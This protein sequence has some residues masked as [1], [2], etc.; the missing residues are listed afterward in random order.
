MNWT[1]ER[2][3]EV[4]VLRDLLQRLAGLNNGSQFIEGVQWCISTARTLQRSDIGT[5]KSSF[6]DSLTTDCIESRIAKDTP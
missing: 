1:T 6:I 3:E 5:L 4:M 2:A